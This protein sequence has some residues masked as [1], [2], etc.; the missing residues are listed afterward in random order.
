VIGEEKT[1]VFGKYRAIDQEKLKVLA[2]NEKTV[3]D[4][5]TGSAKKNALMT[6]AI[7]PVIMFICY[8]ILIFYF[9]AKGGYKAVDLGA[10]AEGG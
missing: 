6:V 2:E 5:V 10:E 7:F 3:I 1:S 8:M 9:R 4:E